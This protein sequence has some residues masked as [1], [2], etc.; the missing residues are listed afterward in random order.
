MLCKS[1]LRNIYSNFQKNLQKSSWFRILTIFASLQFFLRSFLLFRQRAEIDFSWLLVLKIYGLGLFFDLLTLS[2]LALI[3]I[4]YYTVVTSKIFNSRKHQIANRIFYFLFLLVIIFSCFAEI[5]FW[6]EFQTRFNFIAVDYLIYT[7]EVIENI[8][9]SYPIFW[10]ISIITFITAIIFFLTCKKIILSK[11]EKFLYRCQNF[12]AFALFLLTAFFVT[13]S[14]KLSKISANNYAN[15]ISTN[16]IYQLFSAYRNNELD[17]GQLYLTQDNK[18]AILRLRDIISRQEPRSKF[19]NQEDISR[20]IPAPGPGGEKKYNII[21]VMIESMSA[22]FMK[23]FGNSKNITPNL[24]YLAQNSL[25]FTNLKATGTRTVRGLEAVA[26]S[27]PPTPGNSI[28][29]RPH[30]ENMFNIFS[31]L[32]KIGY[33]AKFLYGGDGY[34]DNMN[35]FF[36][37]NGFKIIDRSK[38]SAAEVSFANA[39]GVADEDLFDKTI[40]EADKSYAAGKMF[41]NFVMTTSNHRP[42]TYPGGKIDIPSKTNRDGAVKYSDYAIGRL[43][44]QA[45]KKPW[46]DNTIFIFIADHCAGSAGNTELPLWRY[47]I[48]AIFYA[49][50]IIKPQIFTKN[51][52]QIDIAPTLFGLM[53]IGYRS[54]F[55]GTDVLNNISAIKERAFVSTYSEVGYFTGNKLYLL[56]PKKEKV[57]FDVRIKKYGW[58]GSAEKATKNYQQQKLDDAIAYYQ[59]ASFLFKSN[60]LKNFTP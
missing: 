2:Y 42:F 60:Q 27:V 11:N 1:F 31:P 29:R 34:F 45:Q 15:E 49:P 17:Y 54:K 38:F 52:S 16:G 7:T 35:Y 28:I 13:D 23:S 4:A 48:P 41:L 36:R 43:M 50:K 22:E 44:A 30:N 5:V 56:R 51:V 8:I 55:F 10:L 18:T 19:L 32:K 24:D 46:F 20:Y 40:A 6:E 59:V 33:E 53:N 25:L 21:L 39:W 9:Q 47:Q 58:N 3:P 14:S 37:H 57:V 12:A 26:L